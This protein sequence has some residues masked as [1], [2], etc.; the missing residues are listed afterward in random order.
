MPARAPQQ[1]SSL[2]GVKWRFLSADVANASLVH[3][4]EMEAPFTDEAQRRIT[5]LERALASS[6]DLDSQYQTFLQEAGKH[7]TG[8]QGGAGQL[9]AL[10]K[11]RALGVGPRSSELADGVDLLTDGQT[12]SADVIPSDPFDAQPVMGGR[13]ARPNPRGAPPSARLEGMGMDSSSGMPGSSH[14]AEDDEVRKVQARAAAT[15]DG[16]AATDA[17]DRNSPSPVIIWRHAAPVRLANNVPMDLLPP[18]QKPSA[19]RR[20][21][22]RG[23]E[24]GF[25]AASE[26]PA[27]SPRAAERQRRMAYGAWY[28]P[29]NT[30]ATST[31]GSAHAAAPDKA[32]GVAGGGAA[33]GGAAGEAGEGAAAD[34]AESNSMEL[35]PKL[36]SSRI[37]KEYLKAQHIHRIPHYLAHVESPKQLPARRANI[38]LLEGGG[39]AVGEGSP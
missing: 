18:S 23:A 7:A 4:N 1:R 36:Y 9:D 19:G 16:D 14:T 15:G 20:R 32:R 38:S 24:P 10:G 28:L 17:P 34:G 13:A 37:Y 2:L 29:V 25:G 3:A 33:G 5:Y 22:P 11:S 26:A 8:V 27:V 21:S 12:G 39:A 6:H 35:L 31:V 30:W